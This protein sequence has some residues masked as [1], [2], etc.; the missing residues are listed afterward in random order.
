MDKQSDLMAAGGEGCQCKMADRMDWMLSQAELG[1]FSRLGAW[2]VIGVRTS[3][4]ATP[5][6]AEKTSQYLMI[7][8]SSPQV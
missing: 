8:P 1:R 6:P 5:L 7:A 3:G 4:N 2:V